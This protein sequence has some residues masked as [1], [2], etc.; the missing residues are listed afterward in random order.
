MAS[1][2]PISSSCSLTS[3]CC[4]SSLSSLF[5]V[6][7]FRFSAFTL[8]NSSLSSSMSF[9]NSSLSSFKVLTWWVRSLISSRSLPWDPCWS[10]FPFLSCRNSSLSLSFMLVTSL[11]IVLSC[12]SLVLRISISCSRVKTLLFNLWSSFSASAFSS[13][14]SWSAFESPPMSM[15][16]ECR[17]AASV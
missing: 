17:G 7:N 8:C 15:L 2:C 6:V 14:A 10:W 13:R 3:S 11:T 16:T 4:S 5:S 12:S 9:S 1:L